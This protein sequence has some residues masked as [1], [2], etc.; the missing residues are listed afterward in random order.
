MTPEV[1]KRQALG[2]EAYEASW[3][4]LAPLALSAPPVLYSLRRLRLADRRGALL[5]RQLAGCSGS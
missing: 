3:R 4:V 2:R 1:L 5:C